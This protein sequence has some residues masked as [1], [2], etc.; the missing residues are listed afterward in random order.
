MARTKAAPRDVGVPAGVK[1]V[2]GQEVAL[3]A[4][5]VRQIL[6]GWK[7]KRQL[8][9]AKARLEEVNAALLA[10]H[11]P[12]C[13]LVIPGVCRVSLTSRQTVTVQDAERLRE[14]LGFRFQDLVQVD[15]RYK[16][17]QKL[18]AMSCDGDEP[19]QAAVAACLG[20]QVSEAVTWRGQ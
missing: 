3:T 10:A 18:I 20:V 7:A 11:G 8:E 14:V 4:R 16:P 13:S 5:E 6:D 9:E 15:V 2:D 19:L 1:I 12:G 17:L